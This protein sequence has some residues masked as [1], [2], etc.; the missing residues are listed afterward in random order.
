[1]STNSSPQAVMADFVFGGIEADESRLLATERSACSGIR[2]F[3][4]IAPLDPQAGQPVKITVHIGPEV[5]VDSVAAYVTSDGTDP[6][7]SQGEVHNGFLVELAPIAT[8][9]ESLIWDYV[10]IWQGEIP[11]AEAGALVQYRI[12]GWREGD[13]HSSL[14]SREMNLDRSVERPA[15]YG[16]LVDDYKVPQWAHEAV[17]YQV[18]VDRFAGLP[19]EMANRWLKPQ[20][21]H[22]FAGGSLRGIIDRLDYIAGLGV[23][24]LWLSPVCVTT[25]YHG[26]DTTDY[27]HVDP[28]FGSDAD[29]IELFE[30]AH[31]RGLRVILDFVANHTS[32]EFAPFVEALNDP[33]S[34][35]RNWFTFDPA[36]KHGYRAFFDVA[37][38]P[39]LNTENPEVRDFL[40]RAAQHWL[41][42]GADGLRLDYA[43]GP[44]HLFWS[45]FR[46]ACRGV[47]PDCW[48]FGEV[49]RAGDI[50]QSYAGRLDGCLDFGFC[51]SIRMLAAGDPLLPLGQFVNQ[52]ANGR[53]FFGEDFVLPAFIDNHDMNRFL[54]VAGEDKQ[55]LRLAI[56]LL[57]AL[58][59]PP[60]LSDGTEVGLSQPEGKGP[61]REESRHPMPWGDA[62]DRTLLAYVQEW[63]TARR[64]MTGRCWRSTSAAR[65][66]WLRCRPGAIPPS[67]EKP[68]TAA[69]ACRSLP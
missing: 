12:E 23:T 35:H 18:F 13:E 68:S 55:R 16:Y 41:Q 4:Q 36:Y 21:I 8:R 10:T 50:L 14:W 47:K 58:G 30:A 57:F 22:D 3:H 19:D 26:Y 62:Q 54:W 43:A 9:W 67:A 17:I 51:R 31:S 37:K 2:H 28:R 11:A 61:K 49:T 39:Q 5:V 25:S 44:N 65:R 40:N 56:G 7:G 48:L 15:L 52:V 46:A 27:Y 34:P 69:A 1:M 45:T 38:M 33:D 63:I 59:G 66:R 20:E 6:G 60:I 64:Q 53:R 32:V 42:L 24:A 29:I